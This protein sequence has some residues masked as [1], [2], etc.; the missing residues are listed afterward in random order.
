[1]ENIANWVALSSD[2][3]DIVGN[4]FEAF[5]GLG[6]IAEAVAKVVNLFA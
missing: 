3:H 1:M 2:K 5:T 6:T 4:L